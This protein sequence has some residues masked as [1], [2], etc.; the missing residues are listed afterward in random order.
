MT[1]QQQQDKATMS[2]CN[3]LHIFTLY[4]AK[5]A[6]RCSVDTWLEQDTLELSS[7]ISSIPANTQ[8]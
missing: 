2:S 7:W 1:L 8:W 3:P 5:A 6:V 4:P